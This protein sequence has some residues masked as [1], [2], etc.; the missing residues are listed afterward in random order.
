MT[1]RTKDFD[2]RAALVR[3]LIAG[4]ITRRN[5]RHE[6]TLDTASSGGRAD[7]VVIHDTHLTG[8]EIKSGADT[9]ERLPEQIDCYLRSFDSM[10]L[11]VDERHRAGTARMHRARIGYFCPTNDVLEER[12]SSLLDI[13]LH[14]DAW[15]HPPYGSPYTAPA[16]MARLLWADE[17]IGVAGRGKTREAAMR[18]IRE[19]CS[20][21]HVRAGVVAALRG[22]CLNR[23]EES[24]W[25]RFDDANQ[26]R[27]QS[28]LS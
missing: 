6:L 1:P 3:R 22:R 26:A 16:M 12:Y 5:I 2:L 25:K 28:P 27:E 14:R 18:I 9:L 20:L 10:G 15:G 19:E 17:V 11:F 8:I 7:V 21:K 4:G 24:F 13:A 23:W